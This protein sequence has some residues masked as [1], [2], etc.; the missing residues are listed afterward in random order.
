M[1]VTIRNL[2]V[3]CTRPSGFNQIIVKIDTSEPGLYGLGCA[4]FTYR[5]KAVKSVLEDYIAPL[6]IGRDVS[7]IEDIWQMLNV[8]SYWRN[9]PIINN[10]LS[11]V[12]IALW[13][14]KGKMANMPVYDLLGGKVREAVPVYRYTETDRLET[15]ADEVLRL[16]EEGCRHIRIQWHWHETDTIQ[17]NAPKGSLDGFYMDPI[18][19]CTETVKMFD[20]IRKNC[21]E[22]IELVHDVHE[23]ISSTDSMHLLKELEQYRPFFIEDPVA[24]NQG[25]WLRLIRGQTTTPIAFGELFNN[26]TEWE[27][28]VKDRLLDYMRAHITSIGGITP[29]RKLMALC[30]QFDVLMAWHGS[31]DSSPV[32]HA[33]NMH[34][35]LACTNF[36]IQEW[37]EL[38]NLQYDMYKGA[39]VVKGGFAYVNDKPGLGIEIDEDLMAKYPAEDYK[40]NWIEM[41]RPDGSLQ[42]P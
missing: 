13:D 35:D 10:A 39:P 32:M 17:A 26:P 15:L 14:I 19:M 28:V 37:P 23:R 9:G 31:P 7:R 27:T 36:G 11:G 5:W 3:I 21:G 1:A 16:K 20:Y 4:T 34:L 30:E 41:R 12:D 33:A 22:E 40:T 2:K 6:L 42:K 38:D 18:H 24:P 8:N 29:A 25:E